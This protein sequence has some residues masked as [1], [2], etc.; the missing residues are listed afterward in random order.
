MDLRAADEM[1]VGDLAVFVDHVPIAEIRGRVTGRHPR[2]RH[3]PGRDDGQP[4]PGGRP[5]QPPPRPGQIGVQGFQRLVHLAVPLHRRPL[6]LGR[7][8]GS[9]QATEDR[10]GTRDQP[11]ALRVQNME[12][13]LYAYTNGHGLSLIRTR[14]RPPGRSPAA[15]V[16]EAEFPANA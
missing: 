14:D 13:F 2:E 7:E 12:L 1:L 15:T 4:Q 9:V 5:V 11:P 8:L 16:A 6:Q 3:G 10:T